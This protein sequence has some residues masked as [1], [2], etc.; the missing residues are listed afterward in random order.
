MLLLPS[1]YLQSRGNGR[2]FA[3]LSN[4][5]FRNI[6]STLGKVF[7]ACLKT[8]EAKVVKFDY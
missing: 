7:L 8:R 5:K 1:P 6:N 4:I 2:S 3:K